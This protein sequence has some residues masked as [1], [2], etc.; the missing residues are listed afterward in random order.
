MWE[1]GVIWKKKRKNMQG[2]AFF[3]ARETLES[4]T[5]SESSGKQRATNSNGLEGS[6]HH[7][8]AVTGAAALIEIG[9][10]VSAGERGVGDFFFE[11]LAERGPT[12][13]NVVFKQTLGRD[14][15]ADLGDVVFV[16]LLALAWEVSTEERL[17]ELVKHGVVHAGSPA[18]V[19]NE[20]VLWV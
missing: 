13:V 9:H 3:L 11:E 2:R 17:E 7:L 1:G 16:H 6:V 8:V 10:V 14:Q 20:L 4:K 12:V 18:E 15:T 5:G 19:R